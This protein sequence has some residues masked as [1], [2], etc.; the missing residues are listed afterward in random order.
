MFIAEQLAPF[1]S[2]SPL[3]EETGTPYNWEDGYGGLHTNLG[4]KG[5][6][7]QSSGPI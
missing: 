2:P 3:E 6:I 4:V 1:V 7:F 5:Y